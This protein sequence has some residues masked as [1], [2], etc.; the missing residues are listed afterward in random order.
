[1]QI[2]EFIKSLED[3]FAVDANSIHEIIADFHCDMERGLAGVES[4]LKMLPAYVDRASGKERGRYIALDLGGTNFRVL[5]VELAGGSKPQIIKSEK[6]VIP[7]AVMHGTGVQL[8]NFIAQSI[9]KFML[10]YKVDIMKK[11][12]LGFTFSFPIKQTDIASGILINWTKGFSATGVMG[13]NIVKLLENSLKRYDLGNIKVSALANDTVGTL[14]AKSY[15]DRECDVG[16]IFG[17]GTNAC[18]VENVGRVK[19][20]GKLKYKSDYMIINTEWG[21]FNKVPTTDYDM[22]LDKVSNNTGKQRMEKMISG[23]YVGEIARLIFSDMITK[24]LIFSK[25]KMKFAKGNFLTRHMSLIESDN[26]TRL[27]KINGYL[28]GMGV[29]ASSIAE[30]RAMKDVCRIVSGR[31]ARISAAGISSILT[32]MDPELNYKHTI[33]IDGT[34]YEKYPGFR[35]NIISALR[36]IHSRSSK[37]I[38]LTRAKDGSGIGVAVVAAVAAS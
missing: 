24:K 17:T 6:F 32:W 5:Q 31:A 11:R 34:M 19:K 33:A 30:R 1:M 9:K 23:M 4:S 8:F 37:N 22:K 2:S 36:E 14:A 25:A 15:E 21:N 35:R 28:E 7:K 12:G 3:S 18:Y 16:V 38:K 13:K 10:D 20:M 27:T 26:T 29:I